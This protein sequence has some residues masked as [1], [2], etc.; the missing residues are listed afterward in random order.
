MGLKGG[1]TMYT[2]IDSAQLERAQLQFLGEEGEKHILKDGDAGLICRL[3]GGELIYSERPTHGDRTAKLLGNASHPRV[4]EI[5]AHHFFSK[6]KEILLQNDLLLDTLLTDYQPYDPQSIEAM[7]PNVYRTLPEECTEDVRLKELLTLAGR[8]PG[9]L[10]TDSIEIPSVTAD[11]TTVRS[12]GECIIYNTLLY[13]DIPFKYES[14]IT[15]P[16]TKG[17]DQYRYPDFTIFLK[18]LRKLYWEHA[19]KLHDQKYFR[20]FMNKIYFYHQNGI[21]IGDNLIITAS[22]KYSTIN[23]QTIDRIVREIILPQVRTYSK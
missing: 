14:E 12:L 23:S 11:G 3:Q 19:G 18:N 1:T 15:V 6:Q 21:T 16:L 20:D 9:D 2:F 8:G 22:S 10:S 13:Y 17:L 4:R 7:L 5:K